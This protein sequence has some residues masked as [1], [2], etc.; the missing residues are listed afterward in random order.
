MTTKLDTRPARCDLTSRECCKLICG[1]L[2]GTIAAGIRPAIVRRIFT[3][4]WTLG[5]IAR[6]Q[7]SA[8]EEE[9]QLMADSLTGQYDV[10]E[11]LHIATA[12]TM[13]SAILAAIDEQAAPGA[14]GTAFDWVHERGDDFWEQLAS[15]GP[16]A[17]PMLSQGSA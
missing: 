6:A 3:V 10:S 11:G 1:A 8:S 13:I 16:P 9:R 14:L 17:L 5:D 15:G 12:S 2:S 4:M 7:R